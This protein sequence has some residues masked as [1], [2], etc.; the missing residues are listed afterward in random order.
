M[1]NI[2]SGILLTLI[3]LA[4][5]AAGQPGVAAGQQLRQYTTF[6]L[7][8][9]SGDVLN[10]AGG[11]SKGAVPTGP[12]KDPYVIRLTGETVAELL[13]SEGKRSLT[14]QRGTDVVT[15]SEPLTA[16]SMY[17]VAIFNSWLPKYHGFLCVFTRT[18]Y[19]PPANIV[20]SRY[21]GTAVPIK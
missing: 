20:C 4:G 19:I 11:E 5:I 14:F 16:G 8:F 15:F 17:L 21:V 3:G 1:K 18:V 7:D 10:V 12:R 9:R 2:L 13:G 6:V